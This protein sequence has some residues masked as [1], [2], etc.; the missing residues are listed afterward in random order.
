MSVRTFRLAAT[1]GLAV[2][3]F[4]CSDNKPAR[5][6]SATDALRKAQAAIDSTGSYTLTV[7]QSNFVLPQWGGADG[8]TV[9]V[10]GKGDIATAELA[11]TGEPGATYS[12]IRYQN[13]TYFKRSACETTFRVPG[14]GA[15][16]LR[17]FLFGLTMSL[18][19]ATDVGWIAGSATSIRA[20]VEALGPVTIE[21]DPANGPPV[22]I[23]GQNNSKPLIWTFTAWD[24]RGWAF[25][26]TGDPPNFA[27]VTDRGPG[28]IPC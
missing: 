4:A 15:D 26:F 5:P 6:A 22:R 20:T 3:L 16:V 27:N 17:P 11:R 25:A 2:A 9:K 19:D 21:L 1:L 24:G 23:S 14:G 13:Q 18:A 12:L 10:S 8:G 7:E 28:G